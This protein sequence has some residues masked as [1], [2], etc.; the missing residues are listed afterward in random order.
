MKRVTTEGLGNLK[1]YFNANNLKRR[2]CLEKERSDTSNKLERQAKRTNDKYKAQAQ[3]DRSQS[4]K[5]Q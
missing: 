1:F 5:G 4:K 2:S 3:N